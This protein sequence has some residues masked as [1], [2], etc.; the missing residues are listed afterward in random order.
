MLVL[1]SFSSRTECG[2]TRTNGKS[3]ALEGPSPS[4]K[5]RTKFAGGKSTRMLT[6]KALFLLDD[7]VLCDSAGGVPPARTNKVNS[8]HLVLLFLAIAKW[9]SRLNNL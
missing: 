6:S 3:L 1:S 5:G 4:S 8:R 2:R 9:M 7:Q